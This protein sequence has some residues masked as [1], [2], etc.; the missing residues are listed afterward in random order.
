M[1]K[2]CPRV[3][4]GNCSIDIGFVQLTPRPA[5]SCLVQCTASSLAMGGLLSS[6]SAKPQRQCSRSSSDPAPEAWSLGASV[7]WTNII[8]CFRSAL[9]CVHGP[10][11]PALRRHTGWLVERWFGVVSDTHH[12]DNVFPCPPGYHFSLERPQT[13]PPR[14][15]SS[16]EKEPTL[17]QCRPSSCQRTSF[18]WALGNK[19]RVH[20]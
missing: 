2:K 18:G 7:F 1:S 6:R 13:K 8:A 11:L 14:N 20:G 3:S 15:S 4:A 5:P 16:R 17:N 19:P 9:A 10:V 12:R